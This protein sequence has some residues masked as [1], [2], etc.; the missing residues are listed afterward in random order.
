MLLT[1]LENEDQCLLFI[2]AYLNTRGVFPKLEVLKIQNLAQLS[3]LEDLPL[4]DC[5][6][7]LPALTELDLTNCPLSTEM[8]DDFQVS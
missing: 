1:Q 5:I 3:Q 7:Q 8:Q 2:T 4:I 6:K